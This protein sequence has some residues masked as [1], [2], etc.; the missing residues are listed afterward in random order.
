MFSIFANLV[1]L[2]FGNN[3]QLFGIANS[4]IY[5]ICSSFAEN[6]YIGKMFVTNYTVPKAMADFIV[7]NE[8]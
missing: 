7:N 8:M 5:S 4:Y 1:D 6:F 2:V 3:D